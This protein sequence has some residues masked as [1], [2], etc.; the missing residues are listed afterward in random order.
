MTTTTTTP[1]GPQERKAVRDS[2]TVPTVS[3]SSWTPLGESGASTIV[4]PR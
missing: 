1:I 4:L 2:T 3:T